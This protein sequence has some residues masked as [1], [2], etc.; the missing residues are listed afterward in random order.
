L[1]V[2]RFIKDFIVI[3]H[4]EMSKFRHIV[5]DFDGTI[6]DTSR[7]IIATMQATMRER[8]LRVATPQEIKQVIGLPLNECFL[9]IYPGMSEMESLDCA[10]TYCDIFDINKTRLTPSLFPGVKEAL[11]ALSQRGMTM[12]VASSRG[13][14]SLVELLEMMGV[15]Q[16]FAMVVGVDNVDHAKPHPEAVLTILRAMDIG[17][18]ES[19]MVGDMPVDIAMGK[20]AGTETCAVTYGNSSIEQLQ[21]SKPTFLIDDMRE[22]VSLV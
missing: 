22:L 1:L 20:N 6:A 9:H 5:F 21:E 7:I 13:H 17:T 14:G 11:E 12:S 4:F 8:Q 15:E 19:L 3:L 2:H 16:H 10:S 18:S